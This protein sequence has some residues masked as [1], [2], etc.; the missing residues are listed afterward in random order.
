[1]S[2]YLGDTL[3]QA[4]ARCRDARQLRTG[5]EMVAIIPRSFCN[6]PYFKPFREQFFSMMS[7]R[8]IHV[9]EKRNHAFRDDDVLQENIVLHAVKEGRPSDVTITTSCGATFDVDPARRVCTAEDMT[10]RTVPH[11]SVIRDGDPD[12]FVH[13]AANRIEQG[14]V[15]R[16]AHFKATLADLGVEVSTGPVVDFRLTDDLRAEL[17]EGAVPLLYAAHFR[18]G[19]LSWPKTMRKPNAI[20]LSDKSRKWLWANSGSYVVTRR[21]TSKEERRRIVASVY[22]SD[23]PRRCTTGVAAG[24][25]LVS[26]HVLKKGTGTHVAWTDAQLTVTEP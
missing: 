22:S 17:E 9:F 20:R 15:D 1:M 7:L 4:D 25:V 3:L 2:G 19:K 24:S 21:F 14:I 12:R 6:G 23:A 8:H 11:D 16:M 26:P 10:R 13:I 5:G 18:G